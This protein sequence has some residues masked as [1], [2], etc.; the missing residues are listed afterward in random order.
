MKKLLVLLF[1]GMIH[2]AAVCQKKASINDSTILS[3]DTVETKGDEYTITHYHV[4]SRLVEEKLVH[5]FKDSVFSNG[6]NNFSRLIM[7]GH[8]YSFNVPT[9]PLTHIIFLKQL[10]LILGLSK[11]SNSPYHIVLYSTEGKLLYK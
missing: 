1:V 11:F 4:V 7:N 9:I 6:F 8:R 5:D 2:C 10:G 3:I